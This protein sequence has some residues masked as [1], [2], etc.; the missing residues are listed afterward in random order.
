MVFTSILFYSTD[1][2]GQNT[3]E[4]ECECTESGI[5]LNQIICDLE[6]NGF[7]G[8]GA[9]IV[10]DYEIETDCPCE[11]EG[12]IGLIGSSNNKSVNS[13]INHYVWMNGQ[14]FN[15]KD[16]FEDFTSNI[17]GTCNINIYDIADVCGDIGYILNGPGSSADLNANIVLI[18]T[19]DCD[20]VYVKTAFGSNGCSGFTYIERTNFPIPDYFSGSLKSGDD[21]YY[22]STDNE[23]SI[24]SG[25]LNSN[26]EQLDNTSIVVEVNSYI[27]KD[28]YDGPLAPWTVCGEKLIAYVEI[29]P[30]YNNSAS[31]YNYTLSS[32]YII[33]QTGNVPFLTGRDF[34]PGLPNNDIDQNLT[35][36][37]NNLHYE[38][39]TCVPWVEE[40][41]LNALGF[42][43]VNVAQRV[44]VNF[45]VSS[46]FSIEV[47]SD[48]F[49]SLEVVL[50][51]EGD[52][53]GQ[54]MSSKS[55]K[56]YT[57]P[58]FINTHN[59]VPTTH[60]GQSIRQECDLDYSISSGPPHF[61][62]RF[63]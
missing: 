19:T 24:S 58:S 26:F 30:F 50:H 14:G 27:D 1:V 61:Y 20:F 29:I 40:F 47:F 2:S 3:E 4:F 54:N 36:F 12:V 23:F 21:I 7:V 38:Q 16:Y 17:S 62:Q 10:S 35:S 53:I 37:P 59:L 42:G 11:E 5:D 25:P 22:N 33:G 56:V 63:P 60:C 34:F 32:E 55:L 6:S 49:P 9:T 28:A 18:N 8:I 13:S 41:G 45:S 52:F 31:K 15:I 57:Q 51:G 44:D 46:R 48:I 43:I 39:H